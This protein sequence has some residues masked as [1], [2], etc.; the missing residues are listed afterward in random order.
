MH[1]QL[2]AYLNTFATRLGKL[3]GAQRDDELREIQQHL[4]LLIASH[5]EQGKSEEEAVRLAI[6]QFGRAEKIGRDLSEANSKSN[7]AH[8]AVSAVVVTSVSMFVA[9]GFFSLMNDKSTDFP[10][11]ES[12]KILLAAVLAMAGFSIRHLLDKKKI[13]A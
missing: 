3:P 13:K 8:S 12:D 9:Y 11:H 2:E 5:R 6:S 10:Y 7:K 1:K 4:E